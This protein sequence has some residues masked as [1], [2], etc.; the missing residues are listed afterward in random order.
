MDAVVFV[1]HWGPGMLLAKLDLEKAYWMIPVHPDKQWLLGVRWKD[2]T[3]LDKALRWWSVFV[4][5]WNGIS[6]FPP[7]S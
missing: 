7:A 6:L 3:Y 5:Q 4:A 2:M 1:Q